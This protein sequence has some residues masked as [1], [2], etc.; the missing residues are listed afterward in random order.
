MKAKIIVGALFLSVAAC[1]TGFGFE[2]LDRMLGFGRGGDCC[3]PCEPACKACVPC[4]KPCKPCAPSCEPTTCA[5]PCRAPLVCKPPKCAPLACKAPSCESVGCET[6]CSPCGTKV[7][8]LFAGIKGLLRCKAGGCE[9]GDCGGATCCEQGGYANASGGT[10][11]APA[12][13]KVYPPKPKAL[14]A[15]VPVPDA[16]PIPPA[17][18]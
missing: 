5:K 18:K 6:G 17:A 3:A 2:L 4:C 1:S 15:P 10:A 14:P 11:P 12:P 8:D 13:A 7:R 16:A 9:C